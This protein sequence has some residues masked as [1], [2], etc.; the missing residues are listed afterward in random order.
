[1]NYYRMHNDTT[2]GPP[3][4]PIDVRYPQDAPKWTPGCVAMLDDLESP[5]WWLGL[6]WKGGTKQAEAIATFTARIAATRA[7]CPEGTPIMLYATPC[8]WYANWMKLSPEKRDEHCVHWCGILEQIG[9]DS[10]AVCMYD[11]YADENPTDG[12]ENAGVEWDFQF[13]RASLASMVRETT[14][15]PMNFILSPRQK[16]LGKSPMGRILTQAEVD[17]VITII[18]QVKPDGVVLWQGDTSWSGCLCNPAV[19][20]GE[21][22]RADMRADWAAETWHPSETPDWTLASINRVQHIAAANRRAFA[23]WVYYGTK[24]WT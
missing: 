14:G 4:Q 22:A 15:K 1:M 8:Y 10:L 11:V 24:D 18:N 5:H 12:D 9:V 2:L 6:P 13:G 3:W 23:G 19:P 17:P 20:M 7:A 21:Q 16:G